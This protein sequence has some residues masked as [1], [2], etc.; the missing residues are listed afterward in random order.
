MHHTCV[1]VK[2]INPSLSSKNKAQSK[3]QQPKQRQEVYKKCVNK[4]YDE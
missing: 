1:L 3:L 4:A 2:I